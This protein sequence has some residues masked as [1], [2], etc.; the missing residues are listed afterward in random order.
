MKKEA[1][2]YQ[3][4]VVIDHTLTE[5][6]NVGDVIPLGDSMIGIAVVSGLTDEKIT[7]EIE[8]VWKIDATTADAINVGNV[9]YFNSTTRAITTTEGGNCRAGKAISSKASGT[10]GFVYVKINA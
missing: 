1:I 8:R 6:V 9:V 10:D 5:N 7:V 3:D 2:E 4:G